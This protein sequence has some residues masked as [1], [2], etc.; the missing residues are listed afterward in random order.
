VQAAL[1]YAELGDSM[2]IFSPLGMK[3]EEIDALAKRG[4]AYDKSTK[5]QLLRAYLHKSKPTRE[6]ISQFEKEYSLKLSNDYAEFLMIHNGG[7]PNKNI[8]NVVGHNRVISRF[9]AMETPLTAASLDW[10]ITVYQ[11][12][13]PNGFLPIAD[14]PGSNLFLIDAT[15]SDNNGR[16]YFWSHDG[17]VEEEEQPYFGNMDY[18]CDSFS[19]LLERLI[20]E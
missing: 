13:F 16:V 4:I 2:L 15:R 11:G 6:R 17:E 9:F 14:D 10:V 8:I 18:T 3:Q 19:G 7:H 1:M 5:K 12:R 20:S